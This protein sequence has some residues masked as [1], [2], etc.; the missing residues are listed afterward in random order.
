M[1]IFRR[2]IKKVLYAV[3]LCYAESWLDVIAGKT[4]AQQR[5]GHGDDQ[6]W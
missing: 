5:Q 6:T 2:R 1:E 4:T 3:L